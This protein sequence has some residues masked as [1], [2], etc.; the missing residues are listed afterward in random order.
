MQM[1][2]RLLTA[3]NAAIALITVSAVIFGISRRHG[4]HKRTA[5]RSNP[6]SDQNQAAEREAKARIE[7]LTDLS[8]ARVDDLGAVPAAELTHLMDRATP[9]QLAALA[10][11]FNDAPTDA[12]TLGGMGVFFHAWAQLDPKNALAGAFQLKDI[13]F[14]KLAAI[15]VVNSVS[16]SSTPELIAMLIEHPDKDLLSECKNSFLDPL[17]SSWSSLDPEAASKFMDELGDTKTSLNSRARNNIA[18]NWGTLDPDAALEWVKKQQDKDYLDPSYL[19]DEVIRGWCFKDLGA[20]SAYVAQHLDDPAAERAA[21]S[22]AEAMFTKDPDSATAWV[23]NMP[24]GR[25]KSEAQSTIA[26]T[27]VE[28]DSSAATKWFATLPENEQTDLAGTIVMHWADSNWSEASR[29]IE[30]LSGD[31]RDY[32][33]SNAMNRENVTEAESLTLALS[34]RDEELRHT[35][36][37]NVIQHWSFSDPESAEAWVKNSPLSNEDRDRLLSI[38]LETRNAAAPEATAERVIIDH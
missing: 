36:L 8:Q 21:A 16:P 38:I 24:S 9:D 2:W 20:A 1:N 18:Y 30:T 23:S 14:R 32:A 31:V 12:R 6:T 27:W 22:V 3:I 4:E 28:K 11:K 15:T 5:V 17:I 19:Y 29:W 26:Q 13:T 34:I 33:L 35:R 37:E 10:L 7:A 25:P